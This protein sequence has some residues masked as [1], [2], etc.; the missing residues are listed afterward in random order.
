MFDRIADLVR[1]FGDPIYVLPPVGGYLLFGYLFN[2]QKARTT[3]L[4]AIESFVL[5]SAITYTIKHATHRHRPS[6][7]DPYN[8]WDGPG[9]ESEHLSFPSGHGSTSFA[10]MTVI[11]S[12]YDDNIAIPIICY[13]VATLTSLSRIHDHKHWASDVF[14][15]S[16]VGFV[17]AHTI[18]NRFRPEG[19]EKLNFL[20]KIE[21][22]QFC[23]GILYTF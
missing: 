16:V 4:S 15:G 6:S 8:I 13:S 5:A 14:M 19:D 23:L 22:N 11:A 20:P 7:G 3:A 12:Q 2:N 21:D 18:L 1:P 9:F 17:T 10:I